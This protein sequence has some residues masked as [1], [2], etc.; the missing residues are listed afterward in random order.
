M[1][2]PKC[3]NDNKTN[4]RQ[5]CQQSRINLSTLRR[6]VTGGAPVSEDNIKQ[7]QDIAPN[8]EI[9]VLYG[10]TE[11]EPMAH[12][13][14][15]EMLKGG[16]K[17]QGVN[18]GYLCEDLEYKFIKI[19][20]S[21]IELGEALWEPWELPKG[22]IGE[23]VV[24]GE[25]VCEGY[26]NNPQADRATKIKEDDG[27]IWHRTGDVG[28]LDEQN[29]LWIVGRVHN[30]ILRAQQYLY[31]VQAEILLKKLA[32]VR[33]AAFLGIENSQLGE[34]AVA[35]VSLKEGFCHEQDDQY[36]QQIKQIFSNDHI[37]VD[38]IKIVEDIP[39]D[40]RHHSKVEYTKLKDMLL[41]GQ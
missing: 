33:Q 35:V 6:I 5:Y 12:I 11:V 24:S 37:P 23:L 17:K 41:S 15:R 40:P 27:K 10:S 31:P 26:Y 19:H 38:E 36:I 4:Q 25:H 8:A 2:C 14:G 1:K 32:F 13:T 29:Q 30:C 16:A 20:R 3:K 18:V 34:K 28:F 7:F 9:V 21:A 22:R 39:L